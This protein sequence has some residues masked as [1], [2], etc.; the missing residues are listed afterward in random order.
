MIKPSTKSGQRDREFTTEYGGVK[1]TVGPKP[2]EVPAEAGHYLLR[3]F[4]AMVE[5][6]P[7]TVK[8]K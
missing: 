6:A 3:T 5:E 8:K 7:K 4:S 1:Y 2:V